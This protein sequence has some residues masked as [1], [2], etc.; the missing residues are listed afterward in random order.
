[1]P[2]EKNCLASSK[3][4]I[5]VDKWVYSMYGEYQSWGVWYLCEWLI[6]MYYMNEG[7]WL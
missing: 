7:Y 4:Q 3:S 6:L 5:G 2:L 1:M